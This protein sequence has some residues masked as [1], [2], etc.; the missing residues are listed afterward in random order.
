MSLPARIGAPRARQDVPVRERH[1]Q[2][3]HPVEAVGHELR[4]LREIEEKGA[5]AQRR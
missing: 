3:V 4:H 5:T 1:L 2:L